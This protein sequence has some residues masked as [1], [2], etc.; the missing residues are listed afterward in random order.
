[1]LNSLNKWF[2]FFFLLINI[3]IPLGGPNSVVG[4]AFVVHELE[5]D[6]GKG[7]TFKAINFFL[8]CPWKYYFFCFSESMYLYYLAYIFMF[9]VNSF[10]VKFV[11]LLFFALRGA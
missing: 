10:H 3:Q 11:F 7:G 8:K 6:L 4:R 1:M 9:F 5:D 2:C